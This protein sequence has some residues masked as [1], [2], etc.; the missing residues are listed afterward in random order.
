MF[1]MIFSDPVVWGSLLGILTMIIM[2][3]YYAYIFIYNSD[4]KHPDKGEE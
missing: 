3:A 4:P 1:S 2:A